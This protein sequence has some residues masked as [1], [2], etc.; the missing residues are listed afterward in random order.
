MEKG[1]FPELATAL[2]VILTPSGLKVRSE[3]NLATEFRATSEGLKPV[4]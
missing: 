1:A 2:V 3:I 4:T